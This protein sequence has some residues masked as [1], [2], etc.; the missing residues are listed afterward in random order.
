MAR[1]SNRLHGT[2]FP[3]PSM[4]YM[5]EIARGKQNLGNYHLHPLFSKIAEAQ[6]PLILEPNTYIPEEIVKRIRGKLADDQERASTDEKR[7]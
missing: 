7:V 2:L 6:P 4:F 1:S 3:L 5:I